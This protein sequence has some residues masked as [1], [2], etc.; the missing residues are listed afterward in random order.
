[1]RT[2]EIKTAFDRNC[3]AMRRRPSVARGT[4]R[5]RARMLDGFACEIEEGSWTFRADMHPKHGGTDTGPNPGIFLRAALASCLVMGYIRHAAVANVPITSLEVEVHAD[6][7]AR[8]EFGLA[9]TPPGYER[10]RYEVT[11]E[12]PASEEEILALLDDADA[13]SSILDDLRR[14]I[15]VSRDVRITESAPD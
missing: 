4:A 6:Y 10:V 3:D 12:S 5:T 14:G 2:E 9:D 7:D 1:M 8:G 15:D 13:R 11:V